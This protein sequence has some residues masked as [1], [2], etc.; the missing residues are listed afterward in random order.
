MTIETVTLNA[1]VLF[2]Q[3]LPHARRA[4][5]M[6]RWFG[7]AR[8]FVNQQ[9][10][11]LRQ[12]REALREQLGVRAEL[13]TAQNELIEVRR[14]R[15]ELVDVLRNWVGHCP[16]CGGAGEIPVTDETVR[17]CEFCKPAHDLIERLRPRPAQPVSPN[18][19]EDDITF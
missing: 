10:L 9:D 3:L 16:D 2:T 11:A 6:D 7:V 19:E 1:E 8:N 18:E 12:A 15:D 14:D 17:P 5:A 13:V 4:H